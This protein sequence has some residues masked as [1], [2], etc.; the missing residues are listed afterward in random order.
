VTV[1]GL[2][3]SGKPPRTIAN[4]IEG[5]GVSVG[6]VEG[7]IIVVRRRDDWLRGENGDW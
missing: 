6:W 7:D 5:N 3:S 2:L 4:G 1:E